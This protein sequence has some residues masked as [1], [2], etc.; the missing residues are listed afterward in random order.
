MNKCAICQRLIWPWQHSLYVD[1]L[2][3][4]ITAKH[5]H[6]ECLLYFELQRMIS[7]YSCVLCYATGG[8]A[9]K[10]YD[11]KTCY[12]LIDDFIEKSTK[13]FAGNVICHTS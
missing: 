4:D 9:S 1:E 6:T 11:E 3:G 10:V 8:A 13:L 5:K 12:G 2:L 7:L